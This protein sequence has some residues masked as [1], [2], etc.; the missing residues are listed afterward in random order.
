MG[1]L[2]AVAGAR[3]AVLGSDLATVGYSETDRLT[4]W[5]GTGQ[6]SVGLQTDDVV[7]AVNADGDLL[8][9]S[10]PWPREAAELC[11]GG[12]PE[13][14]VSVR[15]TRAPAQDPQ[16]TP[17]F[18][19][20]GELLCPSAP[21]E[22]LREQVAAPMRNSGTEPGSVLFVP[23]HRRNGSVLEVGSQYCICDRCTRLLTFHWPTLT[24]ISLFYPARTNKGFAHSNVVIA[25]LPFKT[26]NFRQLLKDPLGGILKNL[27]SQPAST[28]F[29]GEPEVEHRSLVL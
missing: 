25:G 15:P 22:T 11:R 16:P 10:V 26:P 23:G 19:A 9:V 14:G 7:V 21:S 13:T 1:V 6:P 17:L 5:L 2:A 20:A 27:R 3:P 8:A 18:P 24:I 29:L 12:V 4:V 28:K